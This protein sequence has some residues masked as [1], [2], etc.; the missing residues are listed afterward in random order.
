[1]KKKLIKKKIKFKRLFLFKQIMKL[2]S[3]I[4]ILIQ[5]Y[6]EFYHSKINPIY[7]DVC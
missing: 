2:K 6:H 5:I 4:I 7:L 1:M 3:N